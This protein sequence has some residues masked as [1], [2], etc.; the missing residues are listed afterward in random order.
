MLVSLSP[1]FSSLPNP[2]KKMNKEKKIES[3]CST[4]SNHINN[5][6]E[7]CPQNIGL[8]HPSVHSWLRHFSYFLFLSLF[9]PPLQTHTCVRT[10][11]STG[12][13][14]QQLIFYVFLS[15]ATSQPFLTA[16][17]VEEEEEKK[18]RRGEKRDSLTPFAFTQ[19]SCLPGCFNI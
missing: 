18:R 13:H 3:L 16:Q 6:D 12:K 10:G 9:S 2:M 1:S 17:T 8:S 14:Q 19:A 4:C 7:K 5:H 11:T 15:Q